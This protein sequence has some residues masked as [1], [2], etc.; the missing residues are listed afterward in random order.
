M[1]GFCILIVVVVAQIYTLL[2]FYKL[3][4]YT[5]KNACET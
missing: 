4:T 3:Y 5:N 1:E 2:R